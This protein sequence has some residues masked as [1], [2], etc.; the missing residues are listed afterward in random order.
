MDMKIRPSV[1]SDAQ[2][3]CDMRWATDTRYQ[4]RDVRMFSVDQCADWL[5]SMSGDSERW[6]VER[7]GPENSK[8]DGDFI[9]LVRIDGIDYIN[10]NCC[11]GLDIAQSY[12]GKGLAK[13]IYGIVL[14]EMFLQR[15]INTVWL[16]VLEENKVAISL[17]VGLGFQT[18]G[19]LRNRIY[20]NGKYMNCLAMSITSTEWEAR[21]K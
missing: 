19:V 4:L 5:A 17:Y 16:E 1:S 10:G 9:G 18:D 2:N 13:K 6:V 20:R 21:M 15:R 8:W 3:V 7:V 12:R 11:V 14:N